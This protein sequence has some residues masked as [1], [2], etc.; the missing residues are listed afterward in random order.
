VKPQKAIINE[1]IAAIGEC[2]MSTKKE[3]QAKLIVPKI[4]GIIRHL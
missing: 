3:L 4:A 2:S 1:K